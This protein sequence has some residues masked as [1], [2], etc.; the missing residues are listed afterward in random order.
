M[1]IC[2]ICLD[3][4]ANTYTT[5][6]SHE[7]CRGCFESWSSQ[8]SSLNVTCPLCRENTID[9]IKKSVLQKGMYAAS[10]DLYRLSGFIGL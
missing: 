1:K 6:C 8:H 4:C 5:P 3:R 7:F 2:P 9:D 10:N